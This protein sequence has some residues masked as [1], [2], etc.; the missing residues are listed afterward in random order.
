[1]TEANAA[2]AAFWNAEPGQ[3]WVPRQ[4]D[5]DA[6]S[7]P[8]SPTSCSTPARPGGARARSTSVAA[9]APPASPWRRRSA[10]PGSVLGLDVSAPLLARAEAPRAL[11]PAKVP[12]GCPDAQDH[13]FAPGGFDLVASRFGLMFFADPVAAFPNI[14]ARLRP[15]G[16]LV[17]V[18][19]AGPEHNPWFTLPQRI[20]VDRLGP[21]PPSAPR[22]AGS[23]GLPRRGPRPRPPGGSRPARRRRRAL[24]LGLHHPGGIAAVLDLAAGIGPLPRLLREKGGTAEDRVAIIAAIRSELRRLCHSRRGPPPR[25]RHR[26]RREHSR[27][28]TSSTLSHPPGTAKSRIPWP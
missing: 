23:D 1:M 5:L 24:D 6:P 22:P 25:P 26:L 17:F 7:P 16:R 10:P 8:R 28:Q 12:F 3:T 19:W 13:P 27:R 9:R 18:A 2:Q 21:I 15:G 11:G 14:P 20:A 4:A